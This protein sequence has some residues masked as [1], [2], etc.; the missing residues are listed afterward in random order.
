M[1]HQF[2]LDRWPVANEIDWQKLFHCACSARVKICSLLANNL[3][4]DGVFS[5]QTIQ[6]VVCRE[7][8]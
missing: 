4:G 1:A 8:E 3:A 5:L 2:S 7:Q 6:L